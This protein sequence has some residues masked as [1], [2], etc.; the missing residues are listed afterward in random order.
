[1]RYVAKKLAG[2]VATVLVVSFL[3]FAAFAVIPG[4]PATSMLGTQATPEKVEALREEMGLNDPLIE[5]FGRWA[6]QF[7][8]GDLGASYS[9]QM[10]VSSMIGEKIP[11]TLAL[12]VMAFLMMVA[13][14]IPVGIFCARHAGGFLDRGITV[15]NQIIMA[16]PPFFSGILITLLF[17]LILHWFT[18]G[19]YVSYTQSVWRFLG[20]LIFP[21]L[22][23]ALPKAAMAVKL[24]RSSV[25]SEMKLDYVRTAYSRGN[26]TKSVLYRHVLKNA[27][28][29]VVTFLGMALADMVAGSIIIEQVFNIPGLGR[30][31]LT[32]ISNRDYPVVQ[33]IIVCIAFLV[34][35]VNFAVDLIYKLVDPR[36]TLD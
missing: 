15:V 2:L 32:S 6:I 36:I 26:R 9:Y 14:S 13:I 35:F 19:G 7:I 3:V 18:P 5:R 17:G 12:T 10:P 22:A 20:Y 23:I 1:M 25:L 8:Q 24:L 4:D 11:V 31:L 21:A 29:P 30:I 27:L 28:I 34:I 16:I 33:A